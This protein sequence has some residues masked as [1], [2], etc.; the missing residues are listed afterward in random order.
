MIT[1]IGNAMNLPKPLTLSVKNI[2]FF[3]YNKIVLVETKIVF[4]P[5][6]SLANLRLYKPRIR[7]GL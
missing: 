4:K 7:L 2:F 1:I 5:K 6:S 3:V